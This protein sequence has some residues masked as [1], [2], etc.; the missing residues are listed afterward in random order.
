[1]AITALISLDNSCVMSGQSFRGVLTVSNSAASAVNI[2]WISRDV[3]ATNG[4]TTGR[5]AFNLSTFQPGLISIPAAG[6]VVLPFKLAIFSPFTP[7]GA[8]V[9]YTINVNVYTDDNAATAATGAT[10][11]YVY[12]PSGTALPPA[13]AFRFDNNNSSPM[14]LLIGF[15]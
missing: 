11:V 7:G 6:S 9:N 3:P 12:P 2:V 14:G 5:V 10:A 8:A 15:P 1:M 4:A 13:A